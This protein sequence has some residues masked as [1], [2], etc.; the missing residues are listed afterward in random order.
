[1]NISLANNKSQK[2]YDKCI[3]NSW[4]LYQTGIYQLKVGAYD[5]FN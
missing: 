3:E 2:I 1:M 5:K 4:Q